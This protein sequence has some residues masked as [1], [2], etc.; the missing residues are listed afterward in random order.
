MFLGER[1]RLIRRYRG[2]SQRQLGA[3]AGV[4]PTRIAAIENSRAVPSLPVLERIARALDVR[5][6]LLFYSVE[7]LQAR[8][9]QLGRKEL[10]WWGP[11]RESRLLLR[12]RTLLAGMSERDR[13]LLLFVASKLKNN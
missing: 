1:I 5:L 3:R 12:F 9:R 11:T 13:G 6:Y 10:L 2:L 4:P 7:Q 8:P